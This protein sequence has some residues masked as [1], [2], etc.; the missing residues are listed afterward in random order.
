MTQ[1]NQTLYHLIC[2]EDDMIDIVAS[3]FDLDYIEALAQRE[4]KKLRLDAGIDSDS[5]TSFF[6]T[7]SEITHPAPKPVDP[8]LEKLKL[9][10][11]AIMPPEEL[12]E[13]IIHNFPKDDWEQE[14][15][16]MMVSLSTLDSHLEDLD[17]LLDYQKLDASELSAEEIKDF[18]GWYNVTLTADDLKNQDL[19]KL[20]KYLNINA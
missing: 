12:A 1:D 17:R 18:E 7:S 6:I 10:S 14:A 11:H 3:S 20:I 2:S 16:N 5:Q 19:R 15:I 9:V 13:A 4:E 8:V